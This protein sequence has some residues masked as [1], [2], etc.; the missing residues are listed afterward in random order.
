MTSDELVAK[1][2]AQENKVLAAAALVILL[3]CTGCISSRAYRLPAIK[4]DEINVTHTDW[5]GSIKASAKGLHVTETYYVWEEAEWTL[6]YGGWQDH[7]I[8]KGYRQKRP[9]PEDESSK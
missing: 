5:A 7:V 3:A 2:N 9:K 8:A 6:S 1:I 4:A